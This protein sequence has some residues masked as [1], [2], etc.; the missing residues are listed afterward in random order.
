M[1]PG[2]F[3]STCHYCGKVGYL[4]LQY[5]SCMESPTSHKEQAVYIKGTSY[6][7]YTKK[8]NCTR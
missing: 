4:C 5:E 8:V 7:K 1:D 3:T 6:Q 2:S